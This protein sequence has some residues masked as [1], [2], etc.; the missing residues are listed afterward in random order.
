MRKT[1]ILSALIVGVFGVT[2]NAYA[3][4][5]AN[6]V[7]GKLTS[8]KKNA[9]TGESFH[10]TNTYAGGLI[11]DIAFK[12][13]ISTPNV[14]IN[15]KSFPQCSLNQVSAATGSSDC[16]KALIGSGTATA[17]IVPCGTHPA[18][19]DPT[20]TVEHFTIQ[21]FNGT[22]GKTL[23][24]K[25]IGV[26][27]AAFT[28]TFIVNETTSATGDKFTFSLAD[29]LLSPAPGN[30]SPIVDATFSIPAKTVKKKGKKIPLIQIAKKGCKGKFG[31]ANLF[32]DGSR[33][34]GGTLTH[35]QIDSASSTSKGC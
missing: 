1:L 22:G 28:G 20:D 3:G 14:V 13:T 16:A 24:S 34:S 11:P 35:N 30:C 5:N 29:P 32:T 8:T 27:L 19:T 4:P 31:Y 9:S 10:L 25:L 12:S 15:G 6:G 7:T 21:I 18:L 17:Y 33:G 26:E 2:A 23:V